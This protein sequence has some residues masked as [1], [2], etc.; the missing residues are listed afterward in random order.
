LFALFAAFLTSPNSLAMQTAA[1]PTKS[2]RLAAFSSVTTTTTEGS[3]SRS[4]DGIGLSAECL[5][6]VK[7][8]H[9]LL[10]GIQKSTCA[11][12]AKIRRVLAAKGGT[13]PLWRAVKP[14]ELADIQAQGIFR[15]LGSAEGK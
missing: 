13:T 6:P 9:V 7:A 12:F 14:E 5:G 10:T 3:V 15:N 11:I 2:A 4:G 8:Y 1:L